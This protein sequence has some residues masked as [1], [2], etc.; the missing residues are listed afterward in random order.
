MSTLYFVKDKQ[1]LHTD[2]QKINEEL[3]IGAEVNTS[4]LIT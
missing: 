2:T 3:K 1:I 4:K